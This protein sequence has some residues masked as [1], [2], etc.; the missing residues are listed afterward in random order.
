MI[1]PV[2]VRMTLNI[3]LY[4][5]TFSIR[6]VTRPFSYLWIVN[7]INTLLGELPLKIIFSCD[8]NEYNLK[9]PFGI[10]AKLLLLRIAT[11]WLFFMY[12]AYN[13]DMGKLLLE[14][15][16]RCTADGKIV[17][18]NNSINHKMSNCTRDWM[19]TNRATTY[20]RVHQSIYI[21]RHN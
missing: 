15:S 19:K 4:L 11:K 14:A 20:S 7:H 2:L 13:R 6:S 10:W 17:P 18:L 8:K 21:F 16:T 1:L 9:E 3:Y 5:G 12:S